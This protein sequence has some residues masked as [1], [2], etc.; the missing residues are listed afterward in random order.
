MNIYPNRIY[1]HF[2]GKY[3]LVAG[4]AVD[5]DSGK[6]LVVYRALYG[7]CRMFVRP[8]EEFLSPVDKKKYPKAIQEYRFELADKIRQED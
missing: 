4:V 5:A 2:K 8:L 7:D 6:L 3:Y 1:R